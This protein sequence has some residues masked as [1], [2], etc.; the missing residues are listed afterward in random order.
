MC[1]YYWQYKATGSYTN[2]LHNLIHGAKIM[3]YWNEQ[4]RFPADQNSN[5]DWGVVKHARNLLSFN[6]KIRMTKQISR[7]CGTGKKMK[8]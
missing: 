1:G 4:G 2:T 7:F 8:H 3:N 5:V 6:R